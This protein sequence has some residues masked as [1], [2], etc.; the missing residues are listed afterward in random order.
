MFFHRFVL[1]EMPTVAACKCPCEAYGLQKTQR[2][3][4]LLSKV[5]RQHRASPT[6]Q[7]R[8]PVIQLKDLAIQEATSEA[9]KETASWDSSN[10]LNQHF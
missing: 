1:F 5:A 2:I 8:V 3:C 4:P 10:P 6:G 7:I 9:I